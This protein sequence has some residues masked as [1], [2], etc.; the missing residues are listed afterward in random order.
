MENLQ[1][2]LKNV[3]GNSSNNVMKQAENIWKM[4]DDMAERDPK[5]RFISN[6]QNLSNQI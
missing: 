3:Q 4:L 2:F 5:V 6:I 1:G